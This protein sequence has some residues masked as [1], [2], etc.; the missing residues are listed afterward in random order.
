MVNGLTHTCNAF[1]VRVSK[2]RVGLL[3]CNLVSPANHLRRPI[4]RVRVAS[5]CG[6]WTARGRTWLQFRIKLPLFGLYLTGEDDSSTPCIT[7]FV[8]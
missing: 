2:C 6:N 4:E 1:A 5:C 7:C 8:D 3:S